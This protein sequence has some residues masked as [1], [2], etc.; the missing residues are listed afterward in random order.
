MIILDTNAWV[1]WVTQSTK[2]TKKALRSIEL[3]KT[4]GV[5]SISCW[6]VAMLTA[7]QRLELSLDVGDWFDLALDHP[8]IRL[9]SISTEIAV[10]STQLPGNFHGD[11]ADRLIVASSLAYDSTLVTKDQKI[12]DWG[13]VPLIW[14]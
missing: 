6:E 14:N 4:I 2:L 13:N 1:W 12:H 7:K 5:C 3:S 9:L 11:P 8:K 10:L